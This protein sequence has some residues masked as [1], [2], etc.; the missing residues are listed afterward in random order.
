MLP[1][2]K[3]DRHDCQMQLINQR[4]TQI[5]PNRRDAASYSNV[6][7]VRRGPGLVERRVNTISNEVKRGAAFHLERCPCVMGK[8]KD[9]RVIRRLISPPAFPT[10]I[11]P[12]S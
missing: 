3:Q 2:A 7:P 11:G 9:R 12:W 5:L 10:F 1:I 6:L 8:H 4:C